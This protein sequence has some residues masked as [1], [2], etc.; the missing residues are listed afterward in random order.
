MNISTFFFGK[1]SERLL[2]YSGKSFVG[3]GNAQNPVN[4]NDIFQIHVS[5][6]NLVKMDILT[7]SDPMCVVSIHE[8]REWRELG[9][10][11]VINNDPNPKWVT[12]F[13]IP[14]LFEVRQILNFS[15]YDVDCDSS[16]L[17]RQDFIGEVTEDLVNILHNKPKFSAELRCS[18]KNRDRGTIHVV[19]ERLMDSGAVIC[20]RIRAIKMRKMGFFG[21]KPFFTISRLVESGTYVPVYRSEVSERMVWAS[22]SIPYQLL[23]NCDSNKEI[24]I[25][26]YHY[27]SFSESQLIGEYSATYTE[28]CNIIG[29]TLQIQSYGKVVCEFVIMDLLR[30]NRYTFLDHVLGGGLQI[31]LITAIDFTASNGDPL[32]PD[33]LHYLTSDGLNQYEACITSIGEVVCPYDS[34]QL[35]PV[36]GFGLYYGNRNYE[37]TNINF[38]G[39]GSVYGLSGI[40]NCYRDALLRIRLSGPTRFAPVIRLSREIAERSFMESRTYTILLIL[41][42]GVIDDM[43]STVDEVVAAGRSPLSIIIIGVG[44]ADFRKMEILDADDVPL[45]SSGGVKMC[46]DIVQFVPFKEYEMVHR[47]CLAQKVLEE[48]PRQVCEWAE[49]NNVRPLSAMN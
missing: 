23:C 22:F 12:S 3:S 19:V 43:K 31:N 20:G 18:G 11:E 2:N 37:C 36:F 32:R 14:Y 21:N 24:K 40:L 48:L 34:D 41:T 17:R 29:D 6:T 27:K 30:H 39:G 8:G 46:R 35:F 25:S 15:V 44:S 16:N 42:D 49:M 9:R 10:T 4:S 47:S 26:F 28:M 5:A 7:E 1:M 13:S 38:Q 33:S 45:V